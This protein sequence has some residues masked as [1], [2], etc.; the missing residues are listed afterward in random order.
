MA[1]GVLAEME[2]LQRRRVFIYPNGVA[3]DSAGNIYIADSSNNRIR[4]VD[5]NGVITTVAG[6]GQWV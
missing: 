5:I 6:N 4:K 1:D 3:V 2:V